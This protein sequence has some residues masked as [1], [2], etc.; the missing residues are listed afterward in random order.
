EEASARGSSVSGEQ[1]PLGSKCPESK[2]PG[3]KCHW[4][5]KVQGATIRGALFW[6]ASCRD[7]GKGNGLIQLSHPRGVVAD[8]LGTV[9]VTDGGNARIGEG[10]QSNQLNWSA[11]LS[12]DRHG[13]LYVA[14]NRHHRVQKFNG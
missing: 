13:N 10:G 3:S 7:S 9:Y 12:F 8:Q 14:D 5:A 2:C 6:R 1:M 11:G 4:G